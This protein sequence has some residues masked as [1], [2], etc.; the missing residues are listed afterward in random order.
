MVGQQYHGSKAFSSAFN[1]EPIL[2]KACLLFLNHAIS[3]VFGQ[4]LLI[5]LFS[6]DKAINPTPTCGYQDL[7]KVGEPDKSVPYPVD[8]LGDLPGPRKRRQF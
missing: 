8:R 5:L 6:S 1:L 2:T 3:F 4:H 7:E